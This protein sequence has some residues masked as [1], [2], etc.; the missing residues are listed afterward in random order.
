M[1][2]LIGDNEIVMKWIC[3]EVGILVNGFLFGGD[4]EDLF[5]EEFMCELWKYYIFVK[6]ILM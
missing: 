3:E 6:L 5:D 2:V 4:I 1:K